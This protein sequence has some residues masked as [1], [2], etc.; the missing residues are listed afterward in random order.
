MTKRS[1]LKSK[2]SQCMSPI[3]YRIEAKL[4]AHVQ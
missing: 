2:T 3:D 1:P 4:A